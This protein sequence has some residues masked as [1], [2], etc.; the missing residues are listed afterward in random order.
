MKPQLTSLVKWLEA[1][2][3][4]TPIEALEHLGIYRLSARVDE[5]RDLGFPIYTELQ[6]QDGKRWALYRLV[7]VKQVAA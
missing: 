7:R 6:Q 2:E 5:L 3:T 1:R 4:I